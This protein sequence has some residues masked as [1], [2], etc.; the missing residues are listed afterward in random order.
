[1]VCPAALQGARDGGSGRSGVPELCPRPDPRPGS[2]LGCTWGH[3]APG[4]DTASPSSCFLAAAKAG[5]SVSTRRLGPRGPGDPVLGPAC[6]RAGAGDPHGLQVSAASSSQAEVAAG[7]EVLPGLVTSPR[8]E[9]GPRCPHGPPAASCAPTA[10]AA[11]RN[12]HP[13]PAPGPARAPGPGQCWGHCAVS[14]G[15]V[16]APGE[17]RPRPGA[18]GS[19]PRSPSP[20]GRKSSPEAAARGPLT[21]EAPGAAG[22]PAVHRG[23]AEGPG[24]AGLPAP[25]TPH[26]VPDQLHFTLPLNPEVR[27]ERASRVPRWTPGRAGNEDKKGPGCARCERRWAAR[28]GLG[29]PSPRPPGSSWV[30]PP[31]SARSC[32]LCSQTSCRAARAAQD[33]GHR[34][35]CWGPGSLHGS[36]G[37]SPASASSRGSR[38]RWAAAPS[39][40]RLLRLP[41]ASPACLRPLF[42][43]SPGR[44][45]G[46]QE[47]EAGRSPLQA[48]AGVAFPHLHPSRLPGSLSPRTASEAR[49]RPGRHPETLDARAQQLTLQTPHRVSAAGIP[50]IPGTRPAPPACRTSSS[51]EPAWNSVRPGGAGRGT[52]AGHPRTPP[53]S[54]GTQP[55]PQCAAWASVR[56]CT[57]RCLWRPAGLSP[58]L[59]RFPGGQAGKN[60]NRNRREARAAR[61]GTGSPACLLEVEL[62]PLPEAQ[63]GLQRGDPPASA[64]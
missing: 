47:A 4:V 56:G 1:M 11:P 20:P 9:R 64:S 42:C 24:A 7:P 15:G 16:L 63:V 52:P 59:S 10:P 61:S 62:G 3:R 34:L 27:A 50:G 17:N 51:R 39:L 36:W 35:P 26:P 41:A 19:P 38:R 49:P 33:P 53:A 5:P 28:P 57:A 40:Q 21:P 13:G 22:N 8:S 37:D 31:G 45:F 12:P 2:G 58:A 18:S 44:C 23:A 60:Q 55:G 30:C 46:V 32:Q 29:A 25:R 6:S 14:L 43:L 48:S 54:D